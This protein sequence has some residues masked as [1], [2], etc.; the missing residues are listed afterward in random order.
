MNSTRRLPSDAA[1]AWNTA[2]EPCRLQNQ[3]L[4]SLLNSTAPLHPLC[5]LPLL[6]FAGFPQTRAADAIRSAGAIPTPRRSILRLLAAFF[7]DYELHVDR[8]PRAPSSSTHYLVSTLLPHWCSCS[9]S[10]TWMRPYLAG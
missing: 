6:T 3:P 10:F 4:M 2:A 5:F 8:T 7:S 9:C 1:T